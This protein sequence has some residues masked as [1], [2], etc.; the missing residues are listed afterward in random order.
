M[1]GSVLR[2]RQRLVPVRGLALHALEDPLRLAARAHADHVRA[3]HRQEVLERVGTFDLKQA[4]G[5]V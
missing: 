4:L 3:G 2:Q 1:R 5:L